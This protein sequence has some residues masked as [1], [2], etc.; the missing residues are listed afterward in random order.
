MRFERLAPSTCDTSTDVVFNVRQ[1]TSSGFFAR[2]FFPDYARAARELLVDE[3]AFTTTAGGRDLE[4]IL[5]HELGHAI[6]FRHEHIRLEP[7]CESEPFEDARELTEY[8]VNSVMHYPHCRPSGTGGY[9]Q[10]EL[11]YAGA[12]S[13][14]GLSPQLILA[15]GS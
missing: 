8:D 7:A 5:R 10:S 9:R 14:Y 3:S 2:A 13:V 12:I 1:I 15:I 6:G 11:D 4:G